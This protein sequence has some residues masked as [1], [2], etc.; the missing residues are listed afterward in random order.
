M[1]RID[2]VLGLFV[3]SRFPKNGKSGTSDLAG[4]ADA[5]VGITLA[6]GVKV[7]ACGLKADAFTFSFEG[8]F[9]SS[10]FL[11]GGMAGMVIEASF[12]R[13]SSISDLL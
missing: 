8:V 5:C 13:T 7:A 4:V 12:D 1:M 3:S 11:N 10:G 2:V 9:F 6:P